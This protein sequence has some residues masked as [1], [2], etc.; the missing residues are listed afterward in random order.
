MIDVAPARRRRSIQR[1]FAAKSGKIKP[2]RSRQQ[3][4]Q[5]QQ[6]ALNLNSRPSQSASPVEALPI[7]RQTKQWQMGEKSALILLSAHRRPRYLSF[8]KSKTKP[9][10]SIRPAAS[11]SADRKSAPGG[12]RVSRWL[13]HDWKVGQRAWQSGKRFPTSSE[14]FPLEPRAH[15][16]SKASEN[17]NDRLRSAKVSSGL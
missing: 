1:L 7:A 16:S 17:Q 4:Q 3:Q 13:A 11:S 9:G 6:A 10:E 2:S 5:Q 15:L 8:K 14:R 12:N